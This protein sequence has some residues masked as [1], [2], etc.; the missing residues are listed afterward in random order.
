MTTTK[1][2][3]TIQE[4]LDVLAALYTVYDAMPPKANI[5]VGVLPDEG[6]KP[7]PHE[8]ERKLLAKENIK[9]YL[10]TL[11]ESA[12]S[13]S[14]KEALLGTLEAKMLTLCQEEPHEFTSQ[15]K[16][17]CLQALVTEPLDCSAQ[18]HE[19]FQTMSL[20]PEI[21]K[22]LGGKTMTDHGLRADPDDVAFLKET[23]LSDLNVDRQGK[24]IFTQKVFR[25][26]EAKAKKMA[27]ATR[28]FAIT[29]KDAPKQ[30]F[31][32]SNR[33]S[34]GGELRGVALQEALQKQYDNNPSQT[35]E[36]AFNTAMN[37]PRY[38]TF[39]RVFCGGGSVTV[40]QK[41]VKEQ[42]ASSGK[43]QVNY[44]RV[45]VKKQQVEEYFITR[46]EQFKAQGVDLTNGVLTKALLL[47][48]LKR[49]DRKAHTTLYKTIYKT[50]PRDEKKALKDAKKQWGATVKQQKRQS[51][52][53]VAKKTKRAK[54]R[55]E[56]QQPPGRTRRPVPEHPS[57]SGK[58]FWILE[59]QQ[60]FNK[61]LVDSSNKIQCTVML[62]DAQ[63]TTDLSSV[64]PH[65]ISDI[66]Y[67]HIKS[68]DAAQKA[69]VTFYNK[70]AADKMY[71]ASDC[72]LAKND[73]AHIALSLT[74]LT[75]AGFREVNV[76]GLKQMD[77]Q[78]GP[79]PDVEAQ[80]KAWMIAKANDKIPYIN[81][82]RHLPKEHQE[83][84]KELHQQGNEARLK[85]FQDDVRPHLKGKE[86]DKLLGVK[87]D[88]RAA[89]RVKQ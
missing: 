54:Q 21:G 13:P 35:I 46:Y 70:D 14:S 76:D 58:G 83:L 27:G 57:I 38:N 67:Y 5:Q 20:N 53:D 89:L 40:A 49:E 60:E 4:K 51:K 88:E 85:A 2:E 10:K 26:D 42:G 75:G 59:Q 15:D 44:Q 74:V 84:W 18:A 87:Q 56:G 78:K 68:T 3:L 55:G 33:E 11:S 25:E 72:V 45:L 24:I 7:D 22:T 34:Y 62:P 29:K 52:K 48:E 71:K 12:S 8:E 65:K 86:M 17:K 73:A 69:E 50:I 41:L 23:K 79:K 9:P 61:Y 47:E 19:T 80:L 32:F 63:K 64:E 77:P 16:I 81:N 66:M 31:Y 28:V 36:E 37:Q 82:S 30:P 43:N 39:F 6:A 1:S